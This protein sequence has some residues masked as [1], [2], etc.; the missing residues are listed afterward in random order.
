M[1]SRKFWGAVAAIATVVGSVVA[2][3]ITWAQ[4]LSPIV[5]A[6]SAWIGGVAIEDAGRKASG[7]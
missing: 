3:E 2:G 1:K 6:I 7:Q 5:I 4:A